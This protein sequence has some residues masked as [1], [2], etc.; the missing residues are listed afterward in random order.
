[1]PNSIIK[2][3]KMKNLIIILTLFLSINAFSSIDTI[4][5]NSSITDVTVFFSGAQI[6][7]NAALKLNKG[8]YLMKIDKLPY[9][10]NSQSIQVKGINNCKI[11][12]VKH[13]LNYQN[14][15]KKNNEEL[16]LDNKIEE[17]EVI[18][19]EIKNKLIVFDLEEKLLFDNRILGTKKEGSKISEIKEAADFYRIRLN[20][21]KHKKLK[22]SIELEQ[23]KE[24][25]RA[26]YVTLNKLTA[27]KRKA[28]SQIIIAID[29]E[30]AISST[31][32]VCYY[33]E[34]AGWEPL[35]DFRVDDITKPLI[36]V[37]N[38]NVYQTSGEDWNNVNIKLSTNNPSLSGGSPELTTW[39]LGKE[40]SYQNESIK[41][42][43]STLK[44]KVY[45]IETNEHLPFAN[46][47]VY[48]NN[49]QIADA[50]T[51]F[52]GQYTIKPVQ[53][54]T[55]V[56]KVVYIGYNPSQTSNI[57]LYPNKTTF[58]DF[59]L[60]ANNIALKEVVIYEKPLID[61]DYTSTG[62]TLTAK[63][64]KVLPT[65]NISA[66]VNTTGGVFSRKK[67][68]LKTSNYISN[69][70]KTKVTNL[71]YIID[72]PY[73]ISSD[74]EDYNIKIKQVAL[75]VEYVYYSAPKLDDDAFLN[76]KITDWIQLNLLSGK[77]SI[78]YQG[79]YIGESLIDVDNASDTL[80]ISLGRDQNIIIMRNGNK[81]MNDKRFFGNT[82]KET[83]GWDII[84]KN[85]K[86]TKIY[87]T[88]EDQY[89]IS[90]K[91]SIEVTLLEY[92][93]AKINEK[94]GKLSWEITL[95]PNEKKV[96]NYQYSVK[97]PKDLY[98]TIE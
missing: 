75:P 64:I 57:R 73:T 9:K 91:K 53:S 19:K 27:Q 63:E 93:E 56:V 88:V 67:K 29:C 58:Q 32:Q 62:A 76:A 35:Y 11:L 42:V 95:E 52:N 17:L 50:T 81:E 5:I 47:I 33:I 96:L 2:K 25:I 84:I 44:G 21:I 86:D 61:P 26:L 87:I 69:S 31:L 45:D 22:L 74:G 8:K 72:I 36:I 71:E 89:P 49:T 24:N 60:Q 14:E 6:T 98:L 90:E 65:R 48:K 46:V 68:S 4:N 37:Y 23:R 43:I 51:D 85:N 7:R 80:N 15:N 12:S 92:S 77:S 79:T 38:A 94:T 3:P 20:E 18:I 66:I 13:Q 16:E 70:L 83:V 10:I 40:Y 97:Y 39:Y 34:S 82:I 28:F 59:K 55:Y 78:Y 30:K 1:M 41:M 54:G